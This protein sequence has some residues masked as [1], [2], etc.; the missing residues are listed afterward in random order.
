SAAASMLSA[1]TIEFRRQHPG[2][3]AFRP[4]I[5]GNRFR[6]YGSPGH[7]ASR[8]LAN[9]QSRDCPFSIVPQLRLGTHS[10]K[11]RFASVTDRMPHWIRRWPNG[12]KSTANIANRSV[13]LGDLFRPYAVR[14]GQERTRP[15]ALA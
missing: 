14:G 12:D 10:A 13:R 9:R 4:P 3:V 2:L 8:T 11:L 1:W 6:N 5:F 15:A 7:P